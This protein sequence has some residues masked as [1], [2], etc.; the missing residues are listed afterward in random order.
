MT[1][2]DFPQFT[3]A[4]REHLRSCLPTKEEIMVGWA[5]PLLAA[6]PIERRVLVAA[7]LEVLEGLTEDPAAWCE[8]ALELAA[9]KGGSD[10]D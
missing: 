2:D 10:A 8:R 3:E 4:E 5:S 1:A 7:Q 6:S 9:G